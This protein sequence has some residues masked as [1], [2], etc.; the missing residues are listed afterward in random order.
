MRRFKSVA[1]AQ[2]FLP[3]QG[4]VLNLLALIIR[5]EIVALAHERANLLVVFGGKHGVQTVRCH[6]PA[7]LLD[8]GGRRRQADKV[9]VQ[10]SQQDLDFRIGD[11]AMTTRGCEQPIATQAETVDRVLGSSPSFTINGNR[12]TLTGP[13]GLGLSYTAA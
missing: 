7:E 13:D 11:L 1:Q 6:E 12:L 3:V 9:E 10:A 8:G 5:N 4:A 2:R